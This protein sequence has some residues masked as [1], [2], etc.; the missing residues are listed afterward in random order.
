MAVGKVMAEGFAQVIV[1]IAW[2]TTSDTV[3]VSV[4]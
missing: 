4:E 3:A 1:G 2:F